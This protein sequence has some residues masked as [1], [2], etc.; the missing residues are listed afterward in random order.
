MLHFSRG[1]LYEISI[2]QTIYVPITYI[3]LYFWSLI[4][5]YPIWSQFALYNIPSWRTYKTKIWL[6]FASYK[7]AVSSLTKRDLSGLSA[8]DGQVNI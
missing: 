5:F 3:L 6:D 2:S 4:K 8:V 1:F 7:H